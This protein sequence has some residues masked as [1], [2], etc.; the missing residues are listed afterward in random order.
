MPGSLGAG[1]R[2]QVLADLTGLVFLARRVAVID[3]V[4][5]LRFGTTGLH[6]RML[7]RSSSSLCV[8]RLVSCRAD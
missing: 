8:P 6:S 1:Q 5:G 3:D 7:T 2:V 4:W